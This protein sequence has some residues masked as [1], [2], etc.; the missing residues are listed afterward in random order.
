LAIPGLLDFVG[1]INGFLMAII[2]GA[3]RLSRFLGKQMQVDKKADGSGTADPKIK[4]YYIYGIAISLLMGVCSNVAT[5]IG[6][7]SAIKNND[8]AGITI[9]L[10]VTM[11]LFAGQI[12]VAVLF[13]RKAKRS[14]GTMP[15]L[16]YALAA[17]VPWIVLSYLS[18]IILSLSG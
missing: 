14:G 17:F 16:I 4:R 12:I 1:F 3:T 13:F 10:L 15:G 11:L 6:W 8:V 5:I 7:Q 18:S 9:S 2:E